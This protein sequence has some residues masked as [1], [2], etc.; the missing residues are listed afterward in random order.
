[1]ETE[2]GTSDQSIE[3]KLKRIQTTLTYQ[4]SDLKPGLYL[5]EK[6]N[7]AT[8]GEEQVNPEA[9]VNYAS[10]TAA[11]A[12]MEKSIFENMSVFFK[13][14]YAQME[15]M[16]KELKG[17]KETAE[18]ALNGFLLYNDEKIE[19]YPDLPKEAIIKRR[20][21]KPLTS[22]LAEE[23]I[24]Y[25]WISPLILQFQHNG[26]QHRVSTKEDSFKI[27]RSLDLVSHMDIT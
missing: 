17:T 14:F 25:S 6:S 21:L 16:Q 1:M 4:P 12:N 22:R 3:P 20:E 8:G 9:L 11:M 26:K 13:R 15:E 19:I 27:L 10:L 23:D 18:K 7:M 2:R 24:K 5:T